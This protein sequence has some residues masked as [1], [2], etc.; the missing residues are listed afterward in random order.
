[1]Y[2]HCVPGIYYQNLDIIG[3]LKA[4]LHT[5]LVCCHGTRV[6]LPGDGWPDLYIGDQPGWLHLYQSSFFNKNMELM[7]HGSRTD[8]TYGTAAAD[9]DSLVGHAK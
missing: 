6:R 2:Y 5:S 7:S 1:M 8:H 4:M 9:A 3:T